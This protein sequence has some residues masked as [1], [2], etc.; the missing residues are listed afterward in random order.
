[1]KGSRPP[2]CSSFSLTM[3]DEDCAVMFGGKTPSGWTSKA[4]ALHLPTVV[5]H[6]WNV[7][8]SIRRYIKI[9]R[10]WDIKKLSLSW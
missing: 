10:L 2:P 1:M 7:E 3:T 8:F 6:L 4:W 9:V 5:S